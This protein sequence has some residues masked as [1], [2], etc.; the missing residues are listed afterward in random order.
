MTRAATPPVRNRGPL[1]LLAALFLVPLALAFTLYYGTDWRPGG[2]TRH[3]DLIDPA[4]PLA[5]VSLLRAD[6]Q[7]TGSGFLRGRWSLVY[8]GAG[9]CDSACGQ[10]LRDTRQIRLA[11]D[12]QA[13]RVQRVFLFAGELRA[14]AQL[15]R[16]HPDLLAARVDDAAGSELLRPFPRFDNQPPAA[17]DRIYIVDP[18]GNLVLSYPPQADRRGVLEDL[19]RLLKLS[20]I[21]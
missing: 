5:E 19:R 3:G 4:R 8:V 20:H 2:S 7:P 9:S 16:D 14:G 18:L 10:A 6:G 13:S 17:A 1:L 12:R 15:T 11:L 21:G